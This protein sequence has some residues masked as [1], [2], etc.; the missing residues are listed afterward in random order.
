MFVTVSYYYLS[1][2]VALKP[3]QGSIIATFYGT[4]GSWSI[5][6]DGKTFVN[7]DCTR[8]NR[9]FAGPFTLP[10]NTTNVVIKAT[11]GC[12]LKAIAGSFSNGVVTDGSWK[13]SVPRK[14][15]LRIHVWW[16]WK[17]NE[18]PQKW[19]LKNLTKGILMCRKSF[20]E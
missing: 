8:Y 17:L 7:N 13:C 10:G 11:N 3:L 5:I 20:G 16:W 6:A 12:L 19:I 15:R 14:I 18:N 1:F 4:I 2:P 9:S